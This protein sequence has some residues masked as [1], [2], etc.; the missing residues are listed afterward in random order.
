[1]EENKELLT[2][3]STEESKPQENQE[4]AT[5]QP[6]MEDLLAQEELS[7][8]LPRAGQLRSGV[9]VGINDDEVLVSIGTKSEGVIPGK[10]LSQLD[11]E[12]REN[13]ELSCN[14]WISDD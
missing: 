7:L 14:I 13:I 2:Q 10:E 5:S 8:D 6:S 1:M 4:E 12:E 11:P 9:V 3:N